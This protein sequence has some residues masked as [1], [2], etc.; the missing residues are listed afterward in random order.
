MLDESLLGIEFALQ[1]LVRP[2]QL[3]VLNLDLVVELLD[4]HEVLHVVLE[5]QVLH[6]LK[7]VLHQGELDFQLFVR[8]F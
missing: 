5:L 1:L 8:R 6:L 3:L 2:V 7:A 4:P